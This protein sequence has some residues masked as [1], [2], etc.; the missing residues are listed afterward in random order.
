[1]KLS[2]AQFGPARPDRA[3]IAWPECPVCQIIAQRANPMGS[4][5]VPMVGAL[6]G[7]WIERNTFGILQHE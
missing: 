3:Q 1:M 4:N 2:T 7:E 6:N 5:R